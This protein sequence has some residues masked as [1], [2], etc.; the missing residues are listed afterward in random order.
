MVSAINPTKPLDAIPAEK[1]D[2]R[3]NFAA[4]KSEIETLQA[5]DLTITAGYQA[6]DTALTAA[7][8]A[9]DAG[10]EE[11][12]QAA[13]AS[14]LTEIEALQAMSFNVMDFAPPGTDKSAV[15]NGAADVWPAMSALGVYLRTKDP[16]RIYEIVF[17]PGYYTPS[18]S[19]TFVGIPYVRFKGYGARIRVPGLV[20]GVSTRIWTTQNPFFE[21]TDY[22]SQLKINQQ[23]LKMGYPV[24]EAVAGSDVITLSVP[25]DNTK[26]T[27]G[28]IAFLSGCDTRRAPSTPPSLAYFE[29]VRVIN[30]ID[31]DIIIEGALRHT[32]RPTWYDFDVS[33]GEGPAFLTPWEDRKACIFYGFEG[34]RI[35]PINL[36]SQNNRGNLSAYSMFQDIKNVMAPDSQ[37]NPQVAQTIRIENANFHRMEMD[38]LCSRVFGTNITTEEMSGGSNLSLAEYKNCK[39]RKELLPQGRGLTLDGCDLPPNFQVYG[40]DTGTK[41]IVNCDMAGPPHRLYTTLASSFNWTF[42]PINAAGTTGAMVF[43][44]GLGN[45]KRRADIGDLWLCQPATGAGPVYAV[46]TGFDNNEAGDDIVYV[47]STGE[48]AEN[49]RI[50]FCGEREGYHWDGCRPD[51]QLNGTGLV[52]PMIVP[53]DFGRGEFNARNT[54]FDRGVMWPNYRRG[55]RP[56]RISV[57]IMKPYTGTDASALLR[58]QHKRV[59]SAW[60]G[61]D[62]VYVNLDFDL[63]T[64][65]YRELSGAGATTE[66]GADAGYATFMEYFSNPSNIM[67]EH[68]CRVQSSI[69]GARI[70]GDATHTPNP[71]ALPSVQIRFEFDVLSGRLFVGTATSAVLPEDVEDSEV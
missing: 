67:V 18:D 21:T 46:V 44:R 29:W 31:G 24:A 12:Y 32:Y 63:K 34:F 54:F 51:L 53:R 58:F 22:E 64:P 28:N 6:A 26:F 13:D 16:K 25:T 15:M 4:A 5:A 59:D 57:N 23:T 9:A 50:Y 43:E 3:A 71:A 19:W 8:Q 40:F 30:I 10:I 11:D 69:G 38:K 48:I 35:E 7:Y 42:V 37:F 45:P 33:L 1:A 55:I 60:T 27:I 66:I 61:V 52:Q 2:L 62:E 39:I 56:A 65:G 70:T 41:T 17:P 20:G 68:T 36:A 14:L 49:G 47:T